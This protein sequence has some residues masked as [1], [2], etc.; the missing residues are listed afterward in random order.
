MNT[1]PETEKPHGTAKQWTDDDL[2][3][4]LKLLN[5]R[6][7][8]TKLTDLELSALVL[9]HIWAQKV[10]WCSREEFLLDEYIS[11][12]ERMAGLKRDEHGNLSIA[13]TNGAE[14]GQA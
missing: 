12:F 11:R 9:H 4:L 7:Q 3:N 2:D 14:A 8:L 13:T 10:G 5:A 6:E 1:N